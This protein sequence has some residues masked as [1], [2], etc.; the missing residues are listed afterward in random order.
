MSIFVT[1]SEDQSLAGAIAAA[2]QP[3]L[4]GRARLSLLFLTWGA[5]LFSRGPISAT[6]DAGA[7]VTLLKNS[8]DDANGNNDENGMGIPRTGFSGTG[9]GVGFA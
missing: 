3:E 9:Y 2:M 7:S 1:N 8:K 6:L 5:R 4:V